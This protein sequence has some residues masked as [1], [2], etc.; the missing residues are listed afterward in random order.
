MRAVKPPHAFQVQDDIA[1]AVKLVEAQFSPY[2]QVIPKDHKKIITVDRMRLIDA[3]RRA[4]LMSS[5][6]RGVKIAATRVTLTSTSRRTIA[7]RLPTCGVYSRLVRRYSRD[8]A[9][10]RGPELIL[11][12][13]PPRALVLLVRLRDV[14]CRSPRERF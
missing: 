13:D 8:I 4:Q 14:I 7:P 11:C 9:H 12:L 2:D 10:D 1:I 3:L 6:T 5:E